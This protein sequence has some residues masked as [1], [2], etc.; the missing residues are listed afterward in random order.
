[1]W[2][3]VNNEKKFTNDE[4]QKKQQGRAETTGHFSPQFRSVTPT[5]ESFCTTISPFKVAEI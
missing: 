5:K 2:G 1:M 4:E 3:R